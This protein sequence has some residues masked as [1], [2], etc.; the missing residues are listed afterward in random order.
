[1]HN[2]GIA[3]TATQP[4]ADPQVHDLASIKPPLNAQPGESSADEARSG[5]G[6]QDTVE[7]QLLTE[8]AGHRA[9][10]VLYDIATAATGE[11]DL[12]RILGATLERVRQLIKFTGGS[13]AL[14]EGDEL[15]LRAAVGPFTREGLG[16]RLPRGSGQSWKVIETQE[17]FLTEDLRAAGYRIKGLEG[18][19]GPRAYLAVPLVWHGESFG[20]L[21]VDS[22]DVDAFGAADLAVMERVAVALSGPIQVALRHASERRALA[23]SEEARRLAEGARARLKL[24]AD[25]SAALASSLEYEVSAQRLAEVT[26]PTLAD[27]CVIDMVEDG[28]SLRR[29]AIA[30]G[31]EEPAHL[32]GALM[33][34]TAP[35]PDES[36]SPV[37]QVLRSGEPLLI[38]EIDDERL[39]AQVPNPEHLR[40]LRELRPR[41][42]MVLPLLGRGGILGV[43]SFVS[44][45]GDRLYTNA[46]MTFGEDLAART[47]VEVETARLYR[48]LSRFRSTVDSL[49]DGVF[50]F[51]PETLRFFYANQ[52][53]ADTTG[54]SPAELL[55]LTP[56]D[57]KPDFDELRFRALIAPLVRGES[58]S[59][60]VTTTYRRREGRDISVELFMQY[61]APRGE[62]G[63][64]ISIVRDVS[65]RVEA[66]ARLQRLAQSERSRNAELKAIIRAM[67]D[68]VLVIGPDGTVSMTNPAAEALFNDTIGSYDKL[69]EM[70]ND[71]EDR[72]PAL[73]ARHGEGPE[74]FRLAG[75]VD[76]WV[77]LSA[78]PVFT[79]R[80]NLAE[81]DE[82]EQVIE[83]ILFM[84]DVTEDRRVRMMRDAFIGVL[85]HELR[86]P[87]TTIYGNSKL[88][89]RPASSLTE[90]L[91]AE[92][93]SDIETEAERLYRL[94]E[95]LLV[96]AR[97]G[98][99]GSRELGHEPLLL[100]R[101]VPMA[102]RSEQAR[103]PGT[104][105]ET[106]VAAGLPTVQAE[107]T[108]V[109]QVVR[110]L[111]SNAA[112]YGGPDGIVAVVVESSEDQV[113]VR[114]LDDGPGFPPE[115]ADQL[116]Q[117]FYRSPRTATV[118][119]GAGIGLFVCRQL[120]EAMG[121][122]MW[123][124]PRPGKGAEFGFSLQVFTEESE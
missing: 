110:N 7:A 61:V 43:I 83:T 70:L 73:G 103:W 75:P 102:V 117:L 58:S 124:V 94:V 105:F 79:P 25:A 63:R 1:M 23:D 11:S 55:T 41:S 84:R 19:D 36:T 90:K 29:V 57:L 121:G 31:P 14:V 33:G 99:G 92:V 34:P 42:A 26:V 18:D 114:V 52:G 47:S 120:I 106:Q 48:D 111:L 35:R 109:E 40:L 15:V 82:A 4:T 88:L 123:A 86:T 22:T 89:R 20:L 104:V 13:I 21:Q 12:S 118:A 24:L 66:R 62:E 112:K 91:R 56:V 119:T 16:Q 76:R 38:P 113:V 69:L 54:Y 74:E 80:E 27:W 46:D 101:I 49:V 45:R 87:V 17:P 78:Y 85:S 77:E 8:R 98:E 107:P 108:Y 97:F 93:V 115:E 81:A 96:L 44:T 100:Q 65:D 72:A 68:A 39:V 2:I 30:R 9:T 10:R 95:D 64:V 37:I 3:A 116:F 32:V 6:E 51:D 53:A 50:M 5:E 60:R 28:G 59:V 122:T 71:P 67:G